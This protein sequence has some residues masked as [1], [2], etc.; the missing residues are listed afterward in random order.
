VTTYAYVTAKDVVDGAIVLGMRDGDTFKLPLLAGPD[1]ISAPWLRLAGID[2]P[3]RGTAEGKVA[4]AFVL[5][6]LK[7]ATETRVM[8]DGTKSFDR[9]VANVRLDEFPLDVILLEAGHAVPWTRTRY[10]QYGLHAPF[11]AAP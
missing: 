8:L 10:A 11:G 2:C 4:K 9:L 7:G 6:K 3:E 1:V 5:E